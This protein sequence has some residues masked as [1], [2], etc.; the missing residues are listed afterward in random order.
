MPARSVVN[1]AGS[2]LRLCT[3]KTAAA[4]KQSPRSYSISA[5]SSAGARFAPSLA[6]GTKCTITAYTAGI[7]RVALPP[8]VR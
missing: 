6:Q 3:V 7:S 8:R 5:R 4:S 2:G 1:A